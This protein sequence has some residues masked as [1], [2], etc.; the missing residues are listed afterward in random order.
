MIARRCGGGVRG[1]R[2]RR[3][4][5]RRARSSQDRTSHRIPAARGVARPQPALVPKQNL[6]RGAGEF[7]DQPQVLA[8]GRVGEK[9]ETR[10]ARLDDDAVARIEFQED[11]F[12]Q[13]ADVLDA[14]T[15]RPAAELAKRRFHGNRLQGRLDGRF[16]RSPPRPRRRCPR[17]MVSTSGNSGICRIRR[18]G[19][20]VAAIVRNSS[21]HSAVCSR[22]HYDQ[23]V[24]RCILGRT[25]HPA[26]TKF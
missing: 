3:S 12:A 2:P 9:N 23:R 6:L 26:E 15:H 25:T 14:A 8:V 20:Q 21:H 17:R 7:D 1:I 4:R 11:P 10:H 24:T 13:P 19:I 18:E 5:W 16:S 22:M